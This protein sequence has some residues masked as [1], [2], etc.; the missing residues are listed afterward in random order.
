MKMEVGEREVDDEPMGIF[1]NAAVTHFHETED[2]CRERWS[3]SPQTNPL[4][5]RVIRQSF[6]AAWLPTDPVHCRP[7]RKQWPS[8]RA[9]READTRQTDDDAPT[10]SRPQ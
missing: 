1:S 4:P 6:F 3:A 8:G 2:G 9:T 10:L 7:F 5:I